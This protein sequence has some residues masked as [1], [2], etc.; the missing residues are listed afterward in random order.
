MGAGL[1]VPTYANIN[2]YN[3]FVLAFWLST[4]PVDV[5]LV[6][7]EA[8]T[9]LAWLGND[10]QTIQKKLK[11]LYNDAGKRVMISAFGAT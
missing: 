8:S 1:G 5:A 11:K 9:Y 4:G 3:Y 7:A 2:P 6:W 10:T